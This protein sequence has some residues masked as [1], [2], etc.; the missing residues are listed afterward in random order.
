LGVLEA[1][2]R[3]GLVSDLRQAYIGLLRQGI[4]FDIRLLQ[5]SLTRLGLPRL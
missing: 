3:R 4:R 2:A 1:G 5:D